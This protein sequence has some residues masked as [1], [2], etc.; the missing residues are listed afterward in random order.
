MLIQH[1]SGAGTFE[2][3]GGKKINPSLVCLPF[4]RLCLETASARMGL[5]CE[6][7]TQVVG[8][9]QGVTSVEI[10]LLRYFWL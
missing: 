8:S 7:Q 10:T 2:S 4:T 6:E 3:S 5:R 9:P 1:R